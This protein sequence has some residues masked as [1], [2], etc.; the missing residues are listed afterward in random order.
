MAKKASPKIKKVASIMST[1][2]T[3]PKPKRPP[4]NKPD[5][6]KR[7]KNGRFA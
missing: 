3:G 2:P 5:D 4:R 7:E 1:R 6:R